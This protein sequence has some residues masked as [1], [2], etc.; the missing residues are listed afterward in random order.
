MRCDALRNRTSPSQPGQLNAAP[1]KAGEGATGSPS[2]FF[3]KGT[4]RSIGTSSSHRQNSR[5]RATFALSI[6]VPAVVRG[7]GGSLKTP[8][9]PRED[10]VQT[11]VFICGTSSISC[12]LFRCRT[13]MARFYQSCDGE[14]GH[15]LLDLSWC[16]LL[17]D[18]RWPCPS[19]PTGPMVSSE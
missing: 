14:V 17:V 3:A 7:T 19:L 5:S 1:A 9:A 15:T 18:L 10:P 2:E 6:V 12:V 8:R 11:C 4:R 13:D 16:C